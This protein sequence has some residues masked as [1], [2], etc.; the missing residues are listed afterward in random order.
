LWFQISLSQISGR[1]ITVQYATANGTATAG[2]DYVPRSGTL[3]FLP[4]WFSQMVSVTV[5]P[6]ALVEEDEFFNLQLSGAVNAVI[7][8]G[9][10]EGMILSDD[11]A[12]AE[13]ASGD[14][15]MASGESTLDAGRD[16]TVTTRRSTAVPPPNRRSPVDVGH[17]DGGPQ[18]DRA[19]FDDYAVDDDAEE[20]EDW[21]WLIE[22][23]S[24]RGS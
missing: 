19:F 11:Q 22:D 9:S 3:T 14:L 8:D 5:N 7:A 21:D 24:L 20:E 10:G 17:L 12:S 6:D 23:S 15:G 2:S 13:L 16:S 4:G 1:S 18:A